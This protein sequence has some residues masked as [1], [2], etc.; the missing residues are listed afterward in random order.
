M[1]VTH[2]RD[3]FMGIIPCFARPLFIFL[4]KEVVECV[5]LFRAPAEVSIPAGPYLNPIS[6]PFFGKPNL[7]LAYF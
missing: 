5:F 6:K 7:N 2:K 3:F 1:N 4:E